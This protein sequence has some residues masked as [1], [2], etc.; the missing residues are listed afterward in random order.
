MKQWHVPYV[1]V[2]GVDAYFSLPKNQREMYG[3][4]RKPWSL[5]LERMGCVE[6]SNDKGWESFY[7]SIKELYPVQWFI[8]EWLLSFDN[9]IY[10]FIK[11]RCM[12]FD[13]LWWNTKRFFKPSCP[14]WR[15]SYKRYQYKDMPA[16]IVDSNFALVLD[17]WHE[18]IPKGHTDWQADEL[19]KEFYS[20]LESAVLYVGFKRKEL[21]EL[22]AEALRTASDKKGK[23]GYKERY[24]E[25]NKLENELEETDA[26]FLYGVIKYRGFFWT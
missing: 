20:W 21:E 13:D 3:L 25:Y 15:A 4:Y 5:P 23:L 26:K 8:R 22:G 7:K 24:G 2:R 16:V 19:H 18:E 11:L 1:N 9:P 6:F 12:K 14:R 17:F 10:S